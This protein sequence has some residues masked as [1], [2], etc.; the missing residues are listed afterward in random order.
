MNGKEVNNMSPELRIIFSPTTD[1][2]ETGVRA[3]P[4]FVSMFNG[5]ETEAVVGAAINCISPNP[6]L[7]PPC[8]SRPP[9]PKPPPGP[10]YG[11]CYGR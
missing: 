7:P 3:I 8:V 2:S 9:L 10:C 1:G 4:Q 6:P 11:S 5:K